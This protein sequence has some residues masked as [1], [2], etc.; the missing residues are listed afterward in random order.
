MALSLSERNIVL[1]NSLRNTAR[2]RAI[3][4]NFV[5]FFADSEYATTCL[6]K[7]EN[8][9][10]AELSTLASMTNESLF[11]SFDSDPAGFD[12]FEPEEAPRPLSPQRRATAAKEL[13]NGLVVDAVGLRSFLFVLKLERIQAAEDLLPLLPQF[14]RLLT[15]KAGPIAARHVTQQVRSML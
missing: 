9:D 4:F 2:K 3:D 6:A 8:S 14:E 13:M 7:F 12:P 1:V 10:D 15:Q 5:K 11:Q